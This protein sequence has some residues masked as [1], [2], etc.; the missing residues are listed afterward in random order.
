MDKIQKLFNKVNN[1]P[2]DVRFND[3]CKL[4]EA[5]GFTYKGGKGS[6]RVY[7]Q[8]GVREILNF[9]NVKGKVK[10]YQVKQ[11]LKLIQE[12]NLRLKEE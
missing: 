11:Y 9:Q 10:P 5:F 2:Y 7:S 8:K 3:I 4:A 1:N 6:H 12:Y